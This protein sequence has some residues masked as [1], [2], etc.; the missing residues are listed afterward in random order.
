MLLK[1]NVSVYATKKGATFSVA[2]FFTLRRSESSGRTDSQG[3]PVRLFSLFCR[4]TWRSFLYFHFR[5]NEQAS[6]DNPLALSRRYLH[7]LNFLT[8]HFLPPVLF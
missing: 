6:S 2:P 4:N 5:A 3:I 1:K 8:Y 7:V